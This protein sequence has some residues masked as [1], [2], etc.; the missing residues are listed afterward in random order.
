MNH[1]TDVLPPLPENIHPYPVVAD[2]DFAE[3]PIFDREGNLY[4]VNYVRNGT[5]GRKTPDGTVSV[6][7]ETGGQANGLKVDGE[8]Y[9][10]A[11]DYGGKRILRIHPDGKRIE[12]LTDSF[13][14]K[15]YLGPN[16]VCLDLAGNIYFS[17]PTGSGKEN[18]I[19][20]VYRIATDGHVTRLDTG[21]A[22]PNGLAVS[23]DQTKFFVAE[24]STNR[25]LAY[26][27]SPDGRLSD[28]RC[29]IQFDTDTLDGIMFDEYG[30]LWIARWTNQTVDI[31]SQ[32]GDLLASLPAGG[33]Q[34][35]NLCF[36]ETSLYLTVAGRHSI[37][38]LDVGVRGA[39]II[40]GG[41]VYRV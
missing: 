33:D 21:L 23:P 37:H 10:I 22:F 27:L 5:I 25:L 17:D 15:P 11:A 6:W 8:G 1:P 29:A 3:G 13:E 12:V 26:D 41:R 38:R 35:T 14:G 31:V 9:V 4:F 30:R 34:A 2:I 7:C 40:P 20:S 19:G 28:K 36:W 32:E 18:L 16:D 39:E 24:S